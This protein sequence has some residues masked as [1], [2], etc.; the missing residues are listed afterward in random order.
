MSDEQPKTYF[1]MWILQVIAVFILLFFFIYIA[2]R[3][4]DPIVTVYSFSV[5]DSHRNFS[6]GLDVVN[7]NKKFGIRYFGMELML[8]TCSSARAEHVI[9]GKTF[10]SFYL[11]HSQS[12]Q[13][14]EFFSGDGWN[15][16]EA[17]VLLKLRLVTVFRFGL[18]G[19]ETGKKYRTTLAAVVPLDE[20]GNVSS[21][22]AK[23]IPLK[24]NRN[25]WNFRLA[26]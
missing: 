25:K 11:Q 3:P 20:N 24:S 21:E 23:Y 15:A 4:S 6:F 9:D 13:W 8:S 22:A 7:N 5:D 17:G 1:L 10:G 18:L 26:V 19:M 12:I 2:I 14:W 16:S